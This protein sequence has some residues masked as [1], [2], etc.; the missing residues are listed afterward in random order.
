MENNNNT[1][2]SKTI[3]KAQA[4]PQNPSLEEQML[5]TLEVF[6]Y[7]LHFKDSL[8]VVLLTKENSLDRLINDFQLINS[9]GIRL[10][11]L[12]K[13]SHSTE[14]KIDKYREKGVNI[15]L[16][17]LSTETLPSE[18]DSANII[19]KALKKTITLLQLNDD[20]IKEAS[21]TET[22][23]VKFSLDLAKNLKARKFFYIH[24][25]GEI[26]NNNKSISHISIEDLEK[27]IH[28]SSNFQSELINLIILS[29]KNTK[30]EFVVI[31]DN[32][33]SMYQEIY[34]HL[35]RG[36]LVTN[37][38]PNEIR[39]GTKKDV[40]M[41]SRLMK[42]YV[43]AGIILPMSENDLYNEIEDFLLYTIN[44]SI[45]AGARMKV[46]DSAVELAK[47]FCLPRFRRRG[48]ARSL[49]KKLIE[50]AKLREKEYIFS[51]SVSSGMWDFLISLGFTEIERESLPE[52]WKRNYNFK[53]NSKAF[54]LP[55]I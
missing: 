12:E 32:P 23:L 21:N 22:T 15:N 47:F 3:S 40:F 24:E 30:C 8:F 4:F 43:T 36:T 35:G 5:D 51:L 28:N 54:K 27:V 52:T 41:V 33:G 34:T 16:I 19:N 7:S 14:A 18:K 13:Y 46:Y 48:H 45:V 53:R 31:D 17:K 37:N 38:Y 6:K 50:N 44:N 9:S 11:I 2:N 20:Y 55:L 1:I 10:L 39:L 29:L 25:D 49:A 26:K 42:P